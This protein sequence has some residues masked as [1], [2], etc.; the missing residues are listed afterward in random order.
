M[1]SNYYI[2][3]HRGV[4]KIRLGVPILN[5]III[6]LRLISHFRVTEMLPAQLMW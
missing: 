2:K 5:F 1:Y 4:M 6:G 3:K